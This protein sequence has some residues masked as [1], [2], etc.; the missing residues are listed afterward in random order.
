M[1]PDLKDY[2]PDL[3]SVLKQADRGAADEKHRHA[4]DQPARA[5]ASRAPVL[6]PPAV[7]VVRTRASSHL[8]WKTIALA[9]V[10]VAVPCVVFVVLY[11]KARGLPAAPVSA[12]MTSATATAAGSPAV[13]SPGVVSPASAAT[14]PG[15]S[16][17]P[18]AS[19][20]PGASAAPAASGAPDASGAGGAAGR[21]ASPSVRPAPK[22]PK[23]TAP[24]APAPST[25]APAPTNVA[26]L[27]VLPTPRF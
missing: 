4:L 25:T 7:P 1:Q 20:P 3:D 18:D 13:V 16:S 10:A 6:R 22:A 5:K 14:A 21:G 24:V 23:P 26:P 2:L 17:A 27:T 12:T 11:E 9:V 8:T 15:A 19:V